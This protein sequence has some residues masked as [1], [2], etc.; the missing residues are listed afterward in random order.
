MRNTAVTIATGFLGSGKTTLVNKALRDSSL[1]TTVVIVNEFGDV[2]IDHDLIETSDD[3]VILL[4]NGCFCCPVKSGLI[5]TL[6]D[7]H[8]KGPSGNVAAFDHVTIEASGSAEPTSVLDVLASHRGVAEL[9]TDPGVVAT[10]DT[11][12]SL[13]T[14]VANV[15]SLNQIAL[16][17]RVPITKTDVINSASTTADNLRRRLFQI[18][19]EETIVDSGASVDPGAVLCFDAASESTCSREFSENGLQIRSHR[20]DLVR[21]FLLVREEPLTFNTLHLFLDAFS[22]T[23]GPNLL[24]VKGIINVAEHSDRPAVN[25]GS[26]GLIHKIGW[27]NQWPREDRRTRIMFCH[28]RCRPEKYGRDS[29]QYGIKHLAR[30]T[31]LSRGPANQG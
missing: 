31:K 6:I 12:N 23:A 5:S 7:L 27:L 22:A 1:H 21:R 19:P 26:Q 13:S 24:R 25:H 20:H 30:R 28:V 17:G 11:I 4:L 16:A 3:F 29:E 8:K 15:T 18:S 2:G 9:Y 10:V 14:L